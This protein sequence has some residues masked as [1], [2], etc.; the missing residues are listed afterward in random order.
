MSKGIEF[1]EMDG[2]DLKIGIVCARWNSDITLPIYRECKKGLLDSNVDEGN[3]VTYHVPG[4]FEVLH[5]AKM[6]IEKE[7]VD[8]VVCIGVLVKGETMHFEYI[9]DAVSKGIMKLNVEG[10]VPVIFGVLTCLTEEQ[11]VARIKD[12]YGW[13]L[14]AVEMCFTDNG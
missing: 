8:A 4:A 11:A 12:G 1:K 13:G 14:S 9:A 5:G 2:S 7:N 6:M 10:K 3:I